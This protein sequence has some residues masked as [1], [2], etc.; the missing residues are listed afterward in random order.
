[1]F[2]NRLN[3]KCQ[4]KCFQQMLIVLGIFVFSYN[5]SNL[6]HESGHALNAVLTG[7]SLNKITMSPLSWCYAWTSGGN[8]IF[9]IWGGFLWQT[10]VPT[11]I[12]LLLWCF[13]SRLSLYA[14][15]L[16]LVSF[17]ESGI[18]MITGAVAGIGDGGNLVRYGIP[19]FILL[20]V[21][22]I[23]L[24]CCLPLSLPMGVLL[25]IERK[26]TSFISAIMVLM[27]I[28]MYLFAMLI[29]N[30]MKNPSEKMMWFGVTIGGIFATVVLTLVIHYFAK[31]LNNKSVQNRAIRV[32][33][34]NVFVS[35]TLAIIILLCEAIFFSL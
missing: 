11:V 28:Q 10:I 35:I 6:I 31:L 4:I 24:L 2:C 17:A 32:S 13:K 9:V 27:P 7:G 3:G 14:L 5:L 30:L 22:S 1:M 25:G 16:V 26:Q 19:P 12:L 33:W 34:S 18:Y 15:F 29:Y 23:L 8:R 20:T 21:G